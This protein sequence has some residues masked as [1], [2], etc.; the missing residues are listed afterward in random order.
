[1]IWLGLIFFT[2]LIYL[3]YGSNVG[4]GI[5]ARFFFFFLRITKGVRIRLPLI[6]SDSTGCPEVNVQ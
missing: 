2:E 4:I 3:M 1:M 5:T 6:A